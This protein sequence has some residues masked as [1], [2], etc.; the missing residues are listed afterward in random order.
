M[1]SG[2]RLREAEG[3][4]LPSIT[5]TPCQTLKPTAAIVPITDWPVK[6]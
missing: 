2:D 6:T 4:L 5:G 3:E 1:G